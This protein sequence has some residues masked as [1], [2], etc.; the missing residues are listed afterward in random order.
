MR[1]EI[2]CGESRPRLRFGSGGQRCRMLFLHLFPTQ[3][4]CLPF[5]SFFRTVGELDGDQVIV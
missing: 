1:V 5:V 2:E 4:M 3:G